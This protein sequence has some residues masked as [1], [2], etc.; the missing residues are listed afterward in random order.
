MNHDINKEQISQLLDN[1]LAG[2]F[3]QPLFQHLAECEEC[4][5]FFLRANAIQE[6]AKGLKPVSVPGEIDRK[7]S[8]L[9]IG[10]QRSTILNRTITISIPSV[11]MSV[12]ALIM[13]TL[14]IYIIGSI[15]EKNLTAQ[16]Q[17]SDSV[18]RSNHS[19]FNDVN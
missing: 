18:V 5:T 8:V 16:Y 3:V 13:M 15:Q 19:L 12:G 7:F 11:I 17:R 1:E 9:A 4:R 14:C 10:D 2:G 6:A